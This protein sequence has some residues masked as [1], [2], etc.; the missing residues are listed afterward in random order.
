MAA[1]RRLMV[2]LWAGDRSLPPH[3]MRMF[4]GWLIYLIINI[5]W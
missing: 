4:I 5:E 1:I 2:A 3:G